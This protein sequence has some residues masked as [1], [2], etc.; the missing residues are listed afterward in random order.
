MA[1]VETRVGDPAHAQGHALVRDPAHVRR[2]LTSGSARWA[3]ATQSV[4]VLALLGLFVFFLLQD[5]EPP[6]STALVALFGVFAF[7][8][9]MA[10]WNLSFVYS[11][12]GLEIFTSVQHHWLGWRSV[13]MISEVEIRRQNIFSMLL[14]GAHPFRVLRIHRAR[15]PSITVRASR[16]IDR[17]DLDV[18]RA[19]AQRNGVEWVVS[20]EFVTLARERGLWARRT[21]V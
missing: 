11:D 4:I 7:T 18:L 12:A 21:R 9:L 15:R 1:V 2:R 5:L 10:V 3:V 13:T 16:G 17:A 6:Y 20:D 8:R 14:S 19:I